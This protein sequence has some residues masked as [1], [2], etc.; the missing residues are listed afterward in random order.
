MCPESSAQAFD[1]FYFYQSVGIVYDP[2]NGS[3]Y[4]QLHRSGH[5]DLP[6]RR[7][8]LPLRFT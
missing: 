8:Y 4:E 3:G 6:C 5:R 7:R 2:F 1:T